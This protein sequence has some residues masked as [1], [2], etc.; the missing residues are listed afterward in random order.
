MKS[1]ALIRAGAALLAVAAAGFGYLMWEADAPNRER[2]RIERRLKEIDVG[3][4]SEAGDMLRERADCQA[5][6]IEDAEHR[7]IGDTCWDTYKSMK[8]IS[9]QAVT[10]LKREQADLQARLLEIVK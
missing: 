7:A 8:V 5:T 2:A 3:L 10:R 9:D 4:R 6:E 1:K